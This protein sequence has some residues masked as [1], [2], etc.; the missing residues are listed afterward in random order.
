MHVDV[1]ELFP[2][3]RTKGNGDV[4]QVENEKNARLAHGR[5]LIVALL[6]GVAALSAWGLSAAPPA[7]MARQPDAAAPRRLAAAAPR[8]LAAAAPRRLAIAAPASQLKPTILADAANSDIV[9]CQAPVFQ[10][11]WTALQRPP[12]QATSVLQGATLQGATAP[13]GATMRVTTMTPGAATD[14]APLNPSPLY[15]GVQPAWAPA[16]WA[17]GPPYG[18]GSYVTPGRTEHV[19]QYRLRVDDQVRFLYRVTRDETSRSYQL[20]VG[21]RIKVELLNQ[22]EVARELV[23]QPDGTITLPLLGQVRATRRDVRQLRSELEERFSKYYKKPQ[24]TVT[25]LKVNT[26]LNDIINTVDSRFGNGGQGV[27]VRLRPDGSISLP[28]LGS[29]RAQGLS[30]DELKTELDRRYSMEV[31]GLEVT[32]ILVTRAPRSVYVMGEV[33]KPGRYVLEGPTTAIQAI[34]L[35]GRVTVGGNFRQVVILRRGVDWRLQGT[36]VDLWDPIITGRPCPNGDV[37]LADS[38]VVI[39]PKQKIL[40]WDEWIDLIFT[41]GIYGVLPMQSLSLNFSKLSSL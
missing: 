1:G 9:L 29:V 17:N 38:D 5:P 4:M 16:G 20:N 27:L 39:V 33:E 14:G 37:W 41:R 7:Q 15:A 28:A 22:T 32:P 19:P 25:P 11:S 6:S 18:H 31:E 2:T 36:M 12:M 3:P 24:V 30:I 23:I 21:D 8:R 26:K 10:R 35:A 13:S 34:A 40:V